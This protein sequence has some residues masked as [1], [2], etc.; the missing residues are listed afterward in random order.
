MQL[1]VATEF[2]YRTT[3]EVIINEIPMKGLLILVIE[4]FAGKVPGTAEFHSLYQISQGCKMEHFGC[5]HSSSE[6]KEKDC[7]VVYRSVGY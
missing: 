1:F 7:S 6:T 4:G 2:V 3:C 5:H